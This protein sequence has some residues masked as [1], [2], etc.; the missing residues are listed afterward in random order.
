NDGGARLALL[1]R[2]S[3][4]VRWDDMVRRH[5]DDPWAYLR[6]KLLAAEGPLREYKLQLLEE[7]KARLFA[8][9]SAPMVQPG[10][11]EAHKETFEG[12]IPLSDYVDLSFHLHPGG[13]REARLEGARSILS[14]AR[15]PTLFDLEALPPERRGKFWD[16]RV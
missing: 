8:D 12:M 11:L 16:K 3:E 7:A 4:A 14:S 6:R 9:L 1:A 10:A 15:T 5:E 2:L 13:D